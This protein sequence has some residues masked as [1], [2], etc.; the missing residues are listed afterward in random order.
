MPDDQ[1]VGMGPALG[2]LPL[3]M[4]MMGGA[5]Q[6]LFGGV[7]TT[8][9]TGQQQ[10]SATQSPFAG[11]LMTPYLQM[12][13]GLQPGALGMFNSAQGMLG[14]MAQG[15][16]PPSISQLARN[17]T[18]PLYTNAYERA[19]EGGRQRGFYDAPATSPPGGAIMAPLLGHAAGQESALTSHLIQ[20]LLPM[21]MNPAQ[22]ILGTA[23]GGMRAAPSLGQTYAGQGTGATTPPQPSVMNTMGQMAP[24]L[25]GLSGAMAQG[26]M[27]QSFGNL[28]GGLRGLFGS[29][30][31]GGS[32]GGGTPLW[33]DFPPDGGGFS[34]MGQDDLSM[35]SG[36][37]A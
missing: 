29:G 15:Q 19:T 32:G 34:S 16:I 25:A 24:W 10:T 31:G 3:L 28:F 7:P 4:M 22:N 37:F 23:M 20:T 35:L 36:Q 30:A 2:M 1:N 5:G 33:Q 14:G 17:I 11:A 26:P 9:K 21:L 12:L 13:Q 27:Q 8:T 6:N 18:Q